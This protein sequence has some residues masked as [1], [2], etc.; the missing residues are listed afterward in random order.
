MYDIIIVGAGPAGMTAAIYALRANKKVLILEA[1][2]Y[3]GQLLAASKIE[4]YPGIDEIT[5]VDLAQDMYEQTKKLGAEFKFE[6]VIKIGDDNTVITN[7][8]EY[9]TKTVIL[10]IG[11]KNRKLNIEGEDKFLGKGL[12]Y[13]ATCDGN[14]FK[15]KVVAVVGGGNTA[16]EDTIYLS[17]IASKVYLI[18]R[19]DEFRAE[20]KYVDEVSTKDNIECIMNSNVTSIEGETSISSITLDNGTKLDVSGLFIAV[21]QEPNSSIFKDFI[22]LDDKGYIIS[23]DGVHT[24]RDKVYVAGDA[25]VKTLRQIVTATSDGAMAAITAIKEMGN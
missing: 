21:G 2:N 8:G 13:C 9:K 12:S 16:L 19:K 18:H 22:E 14:F 7:K 10:A 6:T 25:R 5:G 20:K 24:N 1:K 11:S 3:G 4:N 23:S 17:D 15:G